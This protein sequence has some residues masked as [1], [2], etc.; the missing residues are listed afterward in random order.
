MKQTIKCPVCDSTKISFSQ[1]ADIP[2][3]LVG[4]KLI[5]IT[6]TWMYGWHDDIL[7]HCKD[8][9]NNSEDNLEL[10]AFIRDNF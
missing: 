7:M 3:K 8:C 1:S 6:D 10:S 4:N 2:L 9:G 5:P